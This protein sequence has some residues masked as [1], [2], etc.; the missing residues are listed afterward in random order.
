MNATV[1]WNMHLVLVLICDG[2]GNLKLPVYFLKAK[3]GYNFRKNEK[4]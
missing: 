4:I 3:N 2:N 1:T